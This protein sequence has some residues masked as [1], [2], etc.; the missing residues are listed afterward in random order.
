MKKRKEKENEKSGERKR[1]GYDP[2]GQNGSF[3]EQRNWMGEG[4]IK[5]NQRKDC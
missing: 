5:R 4:R 3:L 2:K 1:K